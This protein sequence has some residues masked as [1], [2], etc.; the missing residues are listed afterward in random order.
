MNYDKILE[1][2]QQQ[3]TDATGFADDLMAG[4]EGINLVQLV[5]E[6]QLVINLA[7]ECGQKCGLKFSSEKSSAILF[8][9]KR[10]KIN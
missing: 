3:R 8:H 1:I 5:Q 2:I 4:K 6:L 7:G 10:K 9:R